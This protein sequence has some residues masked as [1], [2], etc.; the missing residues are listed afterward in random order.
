[1]QGLFY[2]ICAPTLCLSKSK[3]IV[4]RDV[5]A[6]SRGPRERKGE[7][8]VLRFTIKEIDGSTGNASDRGKKAVIDTLLE[9]ACVKGIEIRVERC[10]AVKRN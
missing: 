8:V 10:V 6:S 5:E 2:R 9:P 1:M 3:I 4:R 7:V